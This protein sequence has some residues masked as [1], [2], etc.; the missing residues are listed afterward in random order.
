MEGYTSCGGTIWDHCGGLDNRDCGVFGSTHIYCPEGTHCHYIGEFDPPDGAY[1]A[2]APA[3][4]YFILPGFG[5]PGE[6]GVLRVDGNFVG[7][8]PKD[9]NLYNGPR[10]KPFVQLAMNSPFCEQVFLGGQGESTQCFSLQPGLNI[11]TLNNLTHPWQKQYVFYYPGWQDSDGDGLSDPVERILGTNPNNAD[12]DGDGITDGKE[13]SWY[14]ATNPLKW[15]TDGDG[16]SD[17][18]EI[19]QGT[20]PLDPASRPAYIITV[21]GTGTGSGVVT[22]S[23]S[24]LDCGSACKATYPRNS[25]VTLQALA[26][27]GSYFTGWSGS[28][29][30]GVAPCTLIMTEDKTIVAAFQA[31]PKL[32]ITKAGDGSGVVTSSPSGLDCGATC[33]ATYMPGTEITLMAVRSAGSYFAGWSGGGCSG[34]S[35]CN[36]TLTEDTTIAADFQIQIPTASMTTGRRNHTATLLDDG[37]VLVAGGLGSSDDILPSAELYDSVS[38]TF[39]ITGSM[40]T[41]RA[42]HT[43]TLLLNGKVLL[44]GGYDDI[45][46]FMNRSDALRSAELYDPATET[47]TPNYNIW[48]YLGYG[49]PMRIPRAWHTATLLPEYYIEEGYYCPAGDVL[50]AGGE[51]GIGVWWEESYSYTEKYYSAD[52]VFGLTGEITVMNI[53]RAHH[54]ATLL[55]NGN[56]LLAGGWNPNDG[57]LSSA[58]LYAPVRSWETFFVTGSMTT[59]RADHTATLLPNGKVLVAGGWDSNGTL[60]SAELYDPATETFT[61]T[62]SMTTA[63]EGHTATLLPNGKVLVTGGLG[64]DLGYVHLSSAELYD[65]D[66][67]T[68]AATGSMTTARDGYTATL[69]PNGKVLVTGGWNPNDGTL[70]SAEVYDPAS[71]EFY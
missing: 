46:H 16:Y 70:C 10:L 32:T 33:Q 27:A 9:T 53:G 54:T 71:G 48:P 52:E 49:R 26:S 34:A 14:P 25:Q 40:G 2:P 18:Y 1:C 58:E 55:P 5:E 21:S 28:G 43:A 42:G 59:S 38:G 37:K 7:N 64:Y 65:P 12:T 61:A 44:A 6:N 67:G 47:F 51:G 69:L 41:N 23:P 15:D 66:T 8:S 17:G 68:F 63:R 36:I 35:L 62:G 30:S 3:T 31:K 13:L 11:L 56:V 4:D 29:C 22:S 39:A 20:D 57:T 24:G 45:S 19:A 50:I 60:L